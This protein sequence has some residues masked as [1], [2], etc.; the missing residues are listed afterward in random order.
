M[1]HAQINITPFSGSETDNFN[2]FEQLITGA[3]GVAAIAAAQQANFLQLHLKGDALRYFLTLPE[4]T[5]LIFADSITALRNRFTQDDL[6]EIRIIKLENQKFNP[7]TDTVKNF[8]VKLRTE[9]N[10]AYPAPEIVVVAAGGGDDEARRFER[11]TAARDSALQMSE[12]RKNEQI[13]R[14][15]IKSM[16][17]WLKPKLLERPDT[18]TIDQ[19]CTLASQQ[20]AIREM[21]K[22]EE[23]LDDGFNE[24]TETNT[25]KM[26]K[27]ITTISNNQKQLEQ[28]LEQRSAPKNE[29]PEQGPVNIFTPHYPQQVYRQNYRQNFR[30]QY[31]N[32]RPNYPQYQPNY[33]P[34]QQNYRPQQ[35][36]APRANNYREFRPQFNAPRQFYYNEQQQTR[37]YW[38]EPSDSPPFVHPAYVNRPI[39]RFP[40]KNTPAN[41]LQQGIVYDNPAP[42]QNRYGSQQANQF[43]CACT[44]QNRNMRGMNYPFNQ[45]KN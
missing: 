11:E 33:C 23:Y 41:L 16:P 14:F 29:P 38:T 45:Q 5:R 30:P 18:D 42:A 12:N 35:Q 13:K 27:A 37:N 6:R 24:I 34:V 1:A 15:F 8:L 17:N 2:E 10:K 9:A 43:N 4:A 31:Q 19:L 7:K 22:R 28:K 36:Y 26:L 20:I 3:I 39:Y 44:P 25:D 40:T 21:C 32:Y